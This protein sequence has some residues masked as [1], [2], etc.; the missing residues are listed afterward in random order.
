MRV[1]MSGQAHFTLYKLLLC[2]SVKKV[3]KKT[4][5]EGGFVEKRATRV[6][7]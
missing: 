1:A 4:A 2:P 6:D 7:F 5:A 3:E